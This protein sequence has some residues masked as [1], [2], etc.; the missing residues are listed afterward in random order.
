MPDGLVQ[1]VGF[2][3]RVVEDVW[4]ERF[5]MLFSSTAGARSAP[6]V[7][8]APEAYGFSVSPNP[9][10]LCWSERGD[11]KVRKMHQN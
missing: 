1:F 7:Q 8:C 2:A 9:T 11:A 6:S 4:D 3:R 5:G 10:G